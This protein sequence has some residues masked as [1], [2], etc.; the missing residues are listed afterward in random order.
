MTP[1]MRIQIEEDWLGYGNRVEER[2]EYDDR[3]VTVFGDLERFKEDD[4]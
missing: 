2:V 3:Q 1:R 4:R